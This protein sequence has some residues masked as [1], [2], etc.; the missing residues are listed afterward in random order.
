MG[1]MLPAGASIR[2]ANGNAAVLSGAVATFAELAVNV[3]LLGR[4]QR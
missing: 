2:N 4:I 1:V 3:G